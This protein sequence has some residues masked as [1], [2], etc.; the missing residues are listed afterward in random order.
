MILV[1][2][3]SGGGRGG[4]VHASGISLHTVGTL[5]YSNSEVQDVSFSASVFLLIFVGDQYSV[6]AAC[7][8]VATTALL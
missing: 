7:A 6:M 5:L 4:V 1:K 8:S 3:V 2:C